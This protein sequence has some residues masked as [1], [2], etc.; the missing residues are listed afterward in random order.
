MNAK[1]HILGCGSALP[2]RTNFPTSQILE[3]REKQYMIDCGEGTQIRIR[4]MGLKI[5]RLGHIFISHLHGDHCFGLIGLISTLGMLKR[6]AELHIHGPIGI[7]SIFQ[8]QLDF[9]CEDNSFQ[10]IFHEFN[11]YQH[12]LIHEDKSVLVYSLPLKHRVPCSG[13]LFQEREGERHI[14]RDM[15]DFF[16][17]PLSCIHA[18]KQ[19][20]DYV[21]EAGDII[22]NEKLTLAPN[23]V[24]KYAYC[25]DTAYLEKLVPMINEVDLLYHEATFAESEKVRARQ[26][27]HSTASQAAT[28]GAKANVGKLLIGHF[29][30]R[31]ANQNLL[32]DEAAKCFDR[33]ELAEDMKTYDI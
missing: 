9:F 2:T 6:T 16:Q 33:V 24:I 7:T 4:Q 12:E 29:S 26:T 27:M 5:N 28:I 10:V 31:Y 21:N 13:F 11:A 25:S 14:R 1:L 22:S 30:A 3:L 20:E 8:P 19:G 23:R 17:I 15:I 18:I 32:L